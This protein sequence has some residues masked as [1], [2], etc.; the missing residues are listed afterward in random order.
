[1]VEVTPSEGGELTGLKLQRIKL[2]AGGAVPLGRKESLPVL[3]QECY[4]SRR[5]QDRGWRGKRWRDGKGGEV[6]LFRLV[7]LSAFDSKL[8]CMGL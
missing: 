8:H 7:V 5:F 2:A 4:S 6:A 3:F 1:M